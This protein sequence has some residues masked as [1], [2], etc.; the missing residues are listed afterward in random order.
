MGLRID[1][2]FSVWCD[3]D[4]CAA[5]T[6]TFETPEAAEEEARGMGWKEEKVSGGWN[7]W[8]CAKH[9]KEEDHGE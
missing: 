7:L 6:D 2:V 4:G 5:H 1:N 8:Y 9:K 3:E